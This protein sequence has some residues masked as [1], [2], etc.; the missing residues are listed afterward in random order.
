MRVFGGILVIVGLAFLA[1]PAIADFCPKAETVRL[2]M[3]I[4]DRKA[5]IDDDP[6]GG[7]VSSDP[8]WK[9]AENVAGSFDIFGDGST[10][11]VLRG[12]L[13]DKA[14][15]LSCAYGFS[16][17]SGLGFVS[18]RGLTGSYITLKRGLCR[19]ATPRTWSQMTIGTKKRSQSVWICNS[20]EAKCDFDCR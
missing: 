17:A 2:A 14:G 19:P 11:V 8:E 7:G 1:Q 15:T 6:I 10:Y 12:V 4:Q 20:A 5:G 13:I 16:E 18:K 9:L 3:K